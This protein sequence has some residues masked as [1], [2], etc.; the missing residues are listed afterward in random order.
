MKPA[1]LHNWE[2]DGFATEAHTISVGALG[3]TQCLEGKKTT[4]ASIVARWCFAAQT[5]LDIDFQGTSADVP[6]FDQILNSIRAR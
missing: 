3:P 4:P 2:A 6:T 1:I 5:N